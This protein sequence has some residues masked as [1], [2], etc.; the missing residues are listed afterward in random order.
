M[1]EDRLTNVEEAL[2]G[3]R[4]IRR[5]DRMLDP[6]AD[7]I[8][9]ALELGI[10]F[11][12]GARDRRAR[13][14]ADENL[15]EHGLDR[16][17]ART[18]LAVV[19]RDVT[20]SEHELAFVDDDLLEHRLDLLAHR[21]IARQEHQAGAVAALGRQVDPEPIGLFSEEPVGHLHQDARAVAGIHLASAGAAVQQVDEQ[22]QG[23]ADDA[24]GLLALDVNDE[25]DA[26]GVV[27]VPRIVQPLGRDR[28]VTG[29]RWR[30]LHSFLW[31][32]SRQK[33]NGISR[34]RACVSLMHDP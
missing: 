7:H 20:P 2:L 13:G 32:I 17:R 24:V 12:R 1:F 4:E 11:D 26:A 19:G 6:L 23:L 9:L 18:E 22:L 34:L 28:L 30:R 3:R 25:A 10:A 15:P 27:L 16:H 31:S 14:A 5:V 21:R 33:Q 29:M 8:Q